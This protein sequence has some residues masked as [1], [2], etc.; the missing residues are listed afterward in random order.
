MLNLIISIS[1]ILLADHVFAKGANVKPPQGTEVSISATVAI[2][3]ISTRLDEV[4]AGTRT[5]TDRNCSNLSYSKDASSLDAV[6]NNQIYYIF[7]SPKTIA[8]IDYNP[9]VCRQYTLRTT[10]QIEC[11]ARPV[12]LTN[13]SNDNS[14]IF[15]IRWHDSQ[16]SKTLVRC[17]QVASI[18]F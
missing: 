7:S 8:G 18:A 16:I 12:N 1:F 9:S 2:D 4:I 5:I 11:I 15:Y 14:L 3:S 13:L 17:P 6:V 10:T